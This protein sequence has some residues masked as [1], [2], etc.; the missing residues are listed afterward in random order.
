MQGSPAQSILPSACWS[1]GLFTVEE[2]DLTEA[3]EPAQ[4]KDTEP[5]K[6]L[7][8]ELLFVTVE[9]CK[10]GSNF[11][12]VDWTCRSSNSTDT[13]RPPGLMSL[14]KEEIVCQ[15][16][17]LK[18]VADSGFPVGGRRPVGGPTSDA[19]AFRRKRMQK[20]KNWEGALWIRQ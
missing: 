6:V 19:N 5:E 15:E 9:R 1:L 16:M 20:R 4:P 14:S 18:S 12:V 3:N 17:T 10:G 11:P 7:N 13:R 8:L 2:V